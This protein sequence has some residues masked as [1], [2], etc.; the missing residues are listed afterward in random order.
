MAEFVR[1]VGHSSEVPSQR[2]N[3]ERAIS[4]LVAD[5]DIQDE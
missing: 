3:S 1:T 4:Y 5:D 2:A